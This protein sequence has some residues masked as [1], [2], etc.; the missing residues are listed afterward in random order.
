M[1]FGGDAVLIDDTDRIQFLIGRD[2]RL[3]YVVV[4]GFVGVISS[5]SFSNSSRMRKNF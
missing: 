2:T 4:S 5:C 3:F 1:S